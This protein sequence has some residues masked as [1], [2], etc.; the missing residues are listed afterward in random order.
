MTRFRATW[1]ERE[2]KGGRFVDTVRWNKTFETA[3][4]ARTAVADEALAFLL[5]HP[6]A[7]ERPLGTVKHRHKAVS[8]KELEVH[9]MTCHLIGGRTEWYTHFFTFHTLAVVPV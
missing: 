4:Q 6:P 1:T 9:W 8:G 3:E 2:H 7:G 5:E